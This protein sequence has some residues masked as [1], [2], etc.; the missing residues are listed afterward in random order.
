MDRLHTFLTKSLAITSGYN[1]GYVIMLVE[2]FALAALI[3]YCMRLFWNTQKVGDPE[4]GNLERYVLPNY[5]M[6]VAGKVVQSLLFARLLLTATVGLLDYYRYIRYDSA[7]I[8]YKASVLN[9]CIVPV[10]IYLV[11]A[12]FICLMVYVI[13]QPYMGK[14]EF[15]LMLVGLGVE[16]L[17]MGYIKDVQGQVECYVI[18]ALYPVLCAAI[19]FWG[20]RKEKTWG[21]LSYLKKETEK[22]RKLA[23]KYEHYVKRSL[24]EQEK[25]L[26]A[27]AERYTEEAKKLGKYQRYP[28]KKLTNPGTISATNEEYMMHLNQAWY[29]RRSKVTYA[30][31]DYLPEAG[32]YVTGFDAARA[33]PPL[34]AALGHEENPSVSAYEHL[35]ASVSTFANA[36]DHALTEEVNVMESQRRLDLEIIERGLR[37]EKITFGIADQICQKNPAIRALKNYRIKTAQGSAE[38]DLV[39][40]APAGIICIEVKN[41]GEDGAYAL[42]IQPDGTWYK[43]YNNGQMHA[44][45]GNPFEQNARHVAALRQVFQQELNAV[46]APVLS[47]V[48]VPNDIEIHNH[49]PYAV[50]PA[51]KLERWVNAQAGVLN[52]KQI[53]EV[54]K[55]MEK[56][57]LP[58]LAFDQTDYLGWVKQLQQK[59]EELQAMLDLIPQLRLSEKYRRF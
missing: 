34:F 9:S 42:N 2:C 55:S 27:E 6:A 40:V 19:A 17:A 57:A 21:N 58:P 49:S 3:M 53:A 47:L 44:I 5:G 31:P 15:L 38:S 56:K 32:N 14:P 11:I 48:V 7:F 36:M 41:Y 29:T 8:H 20:I 10:I 30:G 37:G 24:T 28:M 59:E 51:D 18:Y 26:L 43:E 16:T 13:R 23:P 35:R 33:I 1:R 50:K 39:I 45:E 25:M 52:E 54:W 4:G 22:Y 12:G 46:G